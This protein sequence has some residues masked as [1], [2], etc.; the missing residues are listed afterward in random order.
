MPSFM[1]LFW[2]PKQLVA[3]PRSPGQARASGERWHAWEQAL[4]KAG[5]SVTGAQLDPGGRCVHGTAKTVTEG[6]LGGEQLL[7]GYFVITAS[8]LTEATDLAKGCPMLDHGGTVEV[9]P[10]LQAGAG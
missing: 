9:R 7:G 6:A 4:T 10:F 8:S 5:H 2:A 3:A 1:L